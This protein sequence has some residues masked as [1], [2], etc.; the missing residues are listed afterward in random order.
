MPCH[1]VSPS[2]RIRLLAVD[3]VHLAVPVQPAL[4][5]PFCEGIRMLTGD[6]SA[7]P[8][9]VPCNAALTPKKW[10]EK[11]TSCLGPLRHEKSREQARYGTADEHSLLLRHRNCH[12]SHNESGAVCKPQTGATN[13]L[14]TSR[15]L[16]ESRYREKERYLR[17][18]GEVFEKK[19]HWQCSR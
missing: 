10:P 5:A 4:R 18:E 17:G 7:S 13:V 8:W 12:S 14:G 9:R 2:A 6:Q 19:G 11:L 16:S 3:P 1:R 15:C